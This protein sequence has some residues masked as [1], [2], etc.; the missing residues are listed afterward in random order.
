MMMGLI[1]TTSVAAAPGEDLTTGLKSYWPMNEGAGTTFADSISSHNGTLSSSGL[2]SG[3]FVNFA[4][5]SDNGSVADHADFNVGGTMTVFGWVNGAAVDSAFIFTQWD[6][7][8]L[9]RAWFIGTQVGSPS[10]KLRVLI[11]DDGTTDSG[12]LKNYTSSIVLLDSNWRSF[13]FRFNAGTLD[14]F[15]DGVK[16]ASVDKTAADDAITTVFNSSASIM[17]NDILNSGSPQ[18][19]MGVNSKMKKV[20]FYNNAKTDAQIAAMHALGA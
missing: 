6:Y 12:H 13:A 16:D 7:G 3:D 19:T 10:N 17:F 18:G 20:R 4:S 8:A 1:G 15:V 5:S 11:S 14:L 9:Q 2:W